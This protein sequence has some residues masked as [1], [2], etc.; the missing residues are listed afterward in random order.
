MVIEAK[1]MVQ[2]NP[3]PNF[4]DDEIEV[5]VQVLRSAK[6]N[7]WTGEQG[8]LFEQEFADYCGAAYGIAVANGSVG[9][10]V[11]LHVLGIGSG[12][13]VIVTP[14]SFFASAGAIA[15]SGATPVFADVDLD[16]Q[17]ITPESI[18][19]SLS[20]RT[21]AILCVHLNGWPCDMAAIMALAKQ[22]GLFVIE[23]CAQAHGSKIDGKFAGTWGDIGVFSFCQDK[24]MTT[25]GEG[26]MVLT[27]DKALWSKI[28][29]FKDHGKSYERVHATDHPAGFRWLHESIGTNFRMTEVQAAVGR[30]QLLKLDS[31]VQT[32]RKHAAFINK[33]LAEIDCV[34]V[35]TPPAN[36]WHS[37]YKHYVFVRPER[38]IAGWDRDRILR[39]FADA[40]IPA[41]SGACPEIYLEK[42][43][44]DST[45]KPVRRLPAARE[46]G[47][48]S[49]QFLVHPTLTQ[50]QVE[51]VVAIASRILTRA[52][53][54]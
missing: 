44:A 48:T 42:A 35:V 16:S 17:N 13:E 30:R 47:E 49:L 31:W 33:A 6:V 4:A 25:A 36:V 38:V 39:E 3:W 46:L 24:I 53:R 50:E 20:P 37:C 22:H 26:G 19:A 1:K 51:E 41:L 2:L 28:W 21:K 12:D 27:N 18:T 52:Q 7:Y 10:D 54:N 43:F 45:A 32:R 5:A 29:S 15:L 11:A 34:R 9:L 40:G 23:D 14:R 8:R